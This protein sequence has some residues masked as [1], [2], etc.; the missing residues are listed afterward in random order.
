MSGFQFS[1]ASRIGASSVCTP[2]MRTSWP[3]PRSVFMTSYSVFQTYASFFRQFFHVVGRHQ[4]GV[5]E[6]ENA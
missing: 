1:T 5:G 4:V 6:D 3:L 2:S